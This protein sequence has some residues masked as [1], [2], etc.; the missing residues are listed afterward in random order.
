MTITEEIQALKKEKN[1]V[2]LA[3]YYVE[4]QVQEIADYIG[5]SY[6]LSKVASETGAGTIV[7]CG[8]SFMGESAKALNPEKIVLMPDIS[9]WQWYATLILRRNSKGTQTCA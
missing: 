2:I 1:A 9:I 3:H 7:F 4:P 8:V 6:Y 5:D